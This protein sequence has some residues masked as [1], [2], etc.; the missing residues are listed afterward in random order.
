MEE[1]WVG[2]WRRGPKDGAHEGD[3]EIRR[4]YKAHSM[5]MG[6]P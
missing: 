6:L 5:L 3:K 2:S 1:P 4:D